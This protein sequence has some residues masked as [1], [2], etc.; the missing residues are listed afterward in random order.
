MSTAPCREERQGARQH[1]RMVRESTAAGIL[2]TLEIDRICVNWD[3][4]EQN[5]SH[6]LMKEKFG[7]L[8]WSEEP[9]IDG[10]SQTVEDVD[11]VEHEDRDDHEPLEAELEPVEAVEGAHVDEQLREGGRHPAPGP[12]GSATTARLTAAHPVRTSSKVLLNLSKTS[13]L[14][15]SRHTIVLLLLPPCMSTPLS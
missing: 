13:H 14:S 10:G 12:R 8:L 6:I 1:H 4:Q 5:M 9:A 3:Y 7:G 11:K 15:F 2:H